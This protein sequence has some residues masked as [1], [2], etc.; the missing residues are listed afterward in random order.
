MWLWDVSAVQIW[1]MWKEECEKKNEER[2][3]DADVEIETELCRL[4]EDHP[5]ADS[6]DDSPA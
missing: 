5:D 6:L 3:E 4:D 2:N 1:G